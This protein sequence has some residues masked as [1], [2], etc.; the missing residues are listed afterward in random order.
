MPDYEILD[1]HHHVGDVHGVLGLGPTPTGSDPAADE[2]AV[3]LATMDRNGVDRAIVIPGH[4]Y[5]RPSGLADTRRI[6][7]AIAAYRDATPDR[8]PAAVGI[9]EPLY[10]PAGLDEV[11]RCAHELGLRGI[12]FHPLPGRLD[13]LAARPRPR[14]AVR[15]TRT[16]AVRAR[17]RRRPRRSAVESPGT[18]PGV[19][20][21]DVRGAGRVL[22]LRAVPPG[23]LGGRDHPE[24]GV[25]HVARVHVRP[26]RAVRTA[27]RRVPA[28]VRH[29]PVLHA[30]RLPAHPRPR[31]DPRLGAARGR[32]A[33]DPRGEHAGHPRTGAGAARRRRHSFREGV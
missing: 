23:A 7:D 9:V 29:R 28:R 30:A 17:T 13:R 27:P 22:V 15:G 11:D 25:R 6:N 1:C 12:S 4:G 26:R 24:P 2:L 16:R 20:R 32:Q 21:D 18:G 8:F 19:P 31:A 3:R 10:G 33:P 5:L 14:R